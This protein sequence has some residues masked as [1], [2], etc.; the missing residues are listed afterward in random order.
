[1]TPVSSLAPRSWSPEASTWSRSLSGVAVPIP[2]DPR[3]RPSQ[4]SFAAWRR[5]L[6]I[7]RHLLKRL[8]WW[9]L[10]KRC[11]CKRMYLWRAVDGESE[12]PDILSHAETRRQRSKLILKPVKKQCFVTNK[13]PSH[14]A[15]LKHPGLARHHDSGGRKNSRARELS[16]AS[17]TAGTTNAAFQIGPISAAVSLYPRHRLQHLQRPAPSDF[18]KSVT[19]VSQPHNGPVANRHRCRLSLMPI[20]ATSVQ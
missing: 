19:P 17:P 1:M 5:R 6:T 8:P 11:S 2:T 10:E 18:P 3:N 13:R 12:V 4:P 14:G 15:S 16:L 20:L 9:H 7:R